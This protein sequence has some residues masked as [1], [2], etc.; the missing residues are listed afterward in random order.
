MRRLPDAGPH[1]CRPARH[2]G[3]AGTADGLGWLEVDTELAGDKQ[4]V[5]AEGRCRL[6]GAAVHGYEM[7]IG[8]TTGPGL[9][10]PLLDLNG[11]PDGAVSDDGRVLGSYLH[12]LFASDAFR[13]AFLARLK[14]RAASGL[15]YEA[16]VEATLDKLAAHLEGCL[17]LDGF[18]EAA[19]HAG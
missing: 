12:G 4:L 19:R 5:A 13:H 16:E 10:R 6:T 14:D 7:H 17:D 3:P 15:A 18:L 2:E 8:R 9:E 1:P 11:R